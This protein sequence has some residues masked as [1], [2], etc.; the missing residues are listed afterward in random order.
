MSKN[1]VIFISIPSEDVILVALNH[2]I[3]REILQLL[4]QKAMTYTQLMENFT[5]TSGKLN[6]HLKLLTGF[7][8]KQEDGMYACTKLGKRIFTLL[9]NFR[10]S[11]Q[12]EDKSFIKKAYLTQI[13]E[14]KSYL[15]LRLVG[16]LQM[17][18]LAVVSIS[19][20]IAISMI[21][22]AFSGVNLFIVLPFFLVLIPVATIGV[23]WV[24]RMYGPAKK[25]VERVEKLLDES[26]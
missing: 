26:E 20:I 16:G 22:F 5:L 2:E 15:H 13:K 3:R 6:Y 1:L 8:Q 14:D 25:F 9:E 10:S 11:I 19:I 21:L 24:Y 18:I 7:I 17:K 12:D 23:I 4:T